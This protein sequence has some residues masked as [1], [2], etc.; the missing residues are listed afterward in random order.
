MITSPG[1]WTVKVHR[2]M[3]VG[4]KTSFIIIS[5]AGIIGRAFMEG[6]GGGA[7]ELCEGNAHLMAAAPELVAALEGMVERFATASNFS[8]PEITNAR[9][10]IFHARV[11]M[12]EVRP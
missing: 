11:R 4:N 12:P 7:P 2:N 9:L 10:A 8:S 3:I 1:P 6:S 5:K